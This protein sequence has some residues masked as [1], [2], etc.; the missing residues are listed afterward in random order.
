M[1]NFFSI[2][3]ALFITLSSF[4]QEGTIKGFVYD[5]ESGE[6]VI[7]TTVMLKGTSIGISTDVNGYYS[8][9]KIAP[10]DYILTLSNLSYQ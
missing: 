8:I 2:L 10:G 1:R 7:F 3:L 6:P 9:T 4:A 5:K